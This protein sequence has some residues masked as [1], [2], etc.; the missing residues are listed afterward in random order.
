MNNDTLSLSVR[1]SNHLKDTEQTR[2]FKSTNGHGRSFIQKALPLVVEQ[3]EIMREA[4]S[5]LPRTPIYASAIEQLDSEVIALIILVVCLDSLAVPM[6]RLTLAKRVSE[7]LLQEINYS[8]LDA[9]NPGLIEGI[10]RF[11]KASHKVRHCVDNAVKGGEFGTVDLVEWE[12]PTKY[13]VGAVL[14]ESLVKR[15]MLTTVKDPGQRTEKYTWSVEVLEWA[16]DVYER[17][18]YFSPAY[19]PLVTPPLPYATSCDIRSRKVLYENHSYG[20]AFPP[21]PF[22]LAKQGQAYVEQGQGNNLTAANAL[23]QVPYELNRPVYEVMKELWKQGK[24]VGKLPVSTPIEIPPYPA[25]GSDEDIK[26]W[27]STASRIHIENAAG[28]G[29][30]LYTQRQLAITGGFCDHPLYFLWQ[31]DSRGRLYPV[32]TTDLLNPQG[33]DLSKGLLKFHEST[34]KPLGEAGL[35]ALYIA[36]ASHYGIDKVSLDKRV[37]WVMDNFDLIEQVA[38]DPL[39]QGL[40]LW[41]DADSPFQFL[42]ACFELAKAWQIDDPDTYVSSYICYQDGKCS[43]AQHWAALLR[44]EDVGR[45]V[46]LT[47]SSPSDNPPDLYTEVLV[48]TIKALSAS[49]AEGDDPEGYRKWWSYLAEYGKLTRKAVK[50]PTMTYVYGSGRTAWAQQLYAWAKE[51]GL[52]GESYLNDEGQERSDLFKRCSY[53][54][55]I[56][57]DVLDTRLAAAVTGM[58][59]IKSAAKAIT[60]GGYTEI[61]W[62]TPQGF[63][64]VQAYRKVTSERLDIISKALGVRVRQSMQTTTDTVDKGKQASA[65]A[66]N[67]IHSM[68]SAHLTA[69]VI[70]MTDAGLPIS[71]IHDSFGCLACDTQDML[72]EVTDWWAIQYQQDRLQHLRSQWLQLYPDAKI[73]ELPAYGSL[74]SDQVTKSAYA[75]S[76]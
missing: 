10:R 74:D 54:A 22:R 42:A 51:S 35:K 5:R 29:R 59:W 47:P 49:P 61:T 67:Y 17:K 71:V 39:G 64:V 33:S 18:L 21:V 4:T 7:Y 12:L 24:Q 26:A 8:T 20:E 63:K 73:P 31:A 60:K 37:E 72:T 3:I 58:Q 6:N 2:Q 46:G 41:S 15:D 14:L 9:A 68:D 28:T 34:A 13:A 45:S 19:L 57:S 70:S 11:R 66:P 44:D 16:S 55:G 65:I 38:A 25:G 53:L 32:A 52:K 27:K 75:F 62:E 1:A 48:S 43:G 50:P 56:I 23:S 36:A 30:R 76:P 40:E 69:V